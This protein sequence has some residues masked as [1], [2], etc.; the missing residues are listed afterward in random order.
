MVGCPTAS[1]TNLQLLPSSTPTSGTWAYA[2]PTL[3]MVLTFPVAMDQTVIPLIG[4]FVAEVDGVPKAPGT[5]VWN[6]ATH[7]TL[8]YLEAV[9]GPAVVRLQYDQMFPNFVS[10]DA[11]PVFP[12]DLLLTPV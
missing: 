2:D 7:M 8:T 9:L 4:Q 3:T 12:F 6:D 10:L 1:F 5:V 11:Q